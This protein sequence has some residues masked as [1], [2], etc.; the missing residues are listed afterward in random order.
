MIGLSIGLKAHKKRLQSALCLL[1]VLALTGSMMIWP[2]Y[3]RANELMPNLLSNPGFE[4]PVEE[5]GQIPAWTIN[6]GE[7]AL[8]TGLTLEIADAMSH[9]G[10][11]SLYISDEADNAAIVLYSDP[12]EVTA[13]QNYSLSAKTLNGQGTVYVGLRYYRSATDHVISGF[14]PRANYMAV[15]PSESWVDLSFEANAPDE[16][17]Y[18]R[19]LVYT[20]SATMGSAY[21]DDIYFSLSGSQGGTIE[22]ELT[23]LGS[24]VH[25]VNTHRSAFGRDASGRLVAYSTLVGIPAHLLVIDVESET[26]IDQIPIQTTVNGAEY[27][28]TYVRGLV[29]QEDGTVYMAGSP[30]HMFKYVPGSSEVEYV[31]RVA[32]SQVFDMKAGPEGI[33]IG[34][35]YNRSEAFEYNTV[36]GEYTTLG[37]ILEDEFYAYS[38]AYDPLRDEIYFGIGSNARL[39]KLDRTTGTR[40]EITVPEQFREANFIFDMDIAGDKLF[41]RFSP[42]GAIVYDLATGQFENEVY[43]ITSRFVSAPSPVDGK[44]YFTSRNYLGYYDPD[45]KQY[46]RLDA[47]TDGNAYSF[48]FMQIDDP[49]FPGYTLAGITREGRVYKYNLQTGESKYTI[50]DIQGEPTQLQTVARGNDG[51]IHTSGYLSGGNA[52][53]DPLTGAREE[54]TNETKGL[55]QRLAQTDRILSYEDSIY[56]V[57]YPNMNVYEFKQY[58]PWDRTARNPAL[59]FSAF[60]YGEQDRGRGILL[61]EH[62]LM[63]LGTVPKYG[64]LGGA[65]VLYDLKTDERQVYHNVIDQQSVTAVTYKDGM[66]Y[67]GSNIW[68]GLGVDPIATEAKLFIWDIENREKVFEMTPVPGKKGI[69]TMIV[70]PDG[71]IWGS[72]EGE[73][74]I[75][76]PNTREVIHTQTIVNRNYT[77]AVWRDT[78]FEIG[79]DGNVYGVQANKFFVIDA[80]TK[81]MTVIR[82]VGIRNW[83]TQDD[84]G[85]FYLVEEGNLLRIEIPGL[86]RHPIGLQLTISSPILTRGETATPSVKLLLEQDRAVNKIE[87]RES[88][89]YYSSDPSVVR[90]DQGQFTAVNL[91][92]TEVWAEFVMEDGT[93]FVSDRVTINVTATSTIATVRETLDHF[94]RLDE[95]GSVLSKQLTNALNQAEKFINEGK[96]KQAVSHL[97]R[98]LQ[99]LH[100]PELSEQITSTAKAILDADI[101]VLKDS[102]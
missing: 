90:V 92:S 30:S 37:R 10:N 11:S 80:A 94:I 45:S 15:S 66:V 19:I 71:N 82:D 62:G 86:V 51:R 40:T 70:G 50:L 58:E 3:V 28:S 42:G 13:G 83:M 64:L 12:I 27:S 79:A 93:L 75:F 84:F 61:E 34:G 36:T 8:T 4:L 47:Y 87:R 89:R 38:V 48:E 102:L 57:T 98:F 14:I 55:G 16:A 26:L 56:Y 69:T 81:E 54:Y 67:A 21:I 100:N 5:D 46:T 22:Y 85:R 68:G 39:V 88:I 20:T 77:G 74:F 29:V 43:D 65:L 101:R 33:L 73:L 41:M 60:D 23:N 96:Q 6:G 25:T 95:I 78:Q 49:A 32:G 76:D 17:A 91:G 63:I 31:R 9:S 18:A 1:L 97:D 53:Y 99:H 52:I 24:T 44:V 59:L 72:A 7:E 2:S 35:S